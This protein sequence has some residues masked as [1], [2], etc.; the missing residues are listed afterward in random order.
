M[1]FEQELAS[2]KQRIAKAETARDQ[3]RIAGRQEQYL[4]ACST[5]SA[6]DLQLDRL[7]ETQ[8]LAADRLPGPGAGS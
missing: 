6:L 5:V 7:C 8:Q 4:E 2:L 1:T 3:W